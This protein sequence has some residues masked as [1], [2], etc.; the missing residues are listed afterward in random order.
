MTKF[1]I[2]PDYYVA[3][4]N[5]L[6]QVAPDCDLVLVSGGTGFTP[7]DQTPEAV[8]SVLN[9]RADSLVQYLQSEALKITPMACLARTV[10]GMVKTGARR[11]C[12]VV[13][14]P[15]KPKAIAE[16]MEILGGKG[17]LSHALAQSQNSERH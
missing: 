9:K 15:G 5:T 16:N 2:V 12:M 13:T 3:I 7:D 10:I 17:I 8:S 14:L 4:Q 1:R 11:Q 6:R